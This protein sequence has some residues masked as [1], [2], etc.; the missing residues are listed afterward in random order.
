MHTRALNQNIVPSLQ[1]TIPGGLT[2]TSEATLFTADEYD[3]VVRDRGAAVFHELATAM[4]RDQLIQGLRIFYRKGLS[5]HRLTEIDLTDAFKEASGKS[6]E[7]FLT[8]W[9]FNVDE[10]VNQSIDWLD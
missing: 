1:L 8:D 5:V 6:W 7:A 9:L 4:G 10:Y 2:V 3:I